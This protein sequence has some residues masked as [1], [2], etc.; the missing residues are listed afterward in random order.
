MGGW[1]QRM[2]IQEVHT[3]RQLCHVFSPWPWASQG[4]FLKL[5]FLYC[6]LKTLS[7]SLNQYGYKMINA[8]MP[9]HRKC[10]ADVGYYYYQTA[11]WQATCHSCSRSVLSASL[12]PHGLQPTRLLCPWDSPGKST[13]VGCHVLLQGILPTQESNLPSPALVSGFFTTEPLVKR[14]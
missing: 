1:S 11:Y 4:P 10:H 13:G 6:A 3:A 14:E 7:L 2:V 8:T 9:C 5:K 12:R